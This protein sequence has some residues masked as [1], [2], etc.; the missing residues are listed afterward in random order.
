MSWGRPCYQPT[1]SGALHFEKPRQKSETAATTSL[2]GTGSSGLPKNHNQSGGTNVVARNDTWRPLKNPSLQ[3]SLPF[4]TF[5]YSCSIPRMPSLGDGRCAQ[6]L[7]LCLSRWVSQWFHITSKCG[8][9]YSGQCKSTSC[10]H[11][12]VGHRF[13]HIRVGAIFTTLDRTCR[14]GG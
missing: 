4:P 3:T 1:C 12:K 5:R 8:R 10:L 11:C 2:P 6:Y 13:L 9:L 7:H 14:C